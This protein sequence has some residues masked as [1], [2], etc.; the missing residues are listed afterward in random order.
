MLEDSRSLGKISPKTPK[1]LLYLLSM[2]SPMVFRSRT[3]K[4]ITMRI[5]C[6]Y[7]LSIVI[8]KCLIELDYN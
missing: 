3:N 7:N 6:L 4:A 1:T 5:L 2:L 8:E